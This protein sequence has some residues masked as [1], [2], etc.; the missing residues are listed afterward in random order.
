MVQARS[1]KVI[2]LLPNAAR[3]I[4]AL[5]ENGISFQAAVAD[6]IDNS[7]EAQATRVDVTMMFDGKASWVRVA[8]NGEGMDAKT[9]TEAMRYGTDRNYDEHDL[10]KFGMGMKTAPLSQCRCLTVASRVS[11]SQRRIE[12][13]RWDIQEIE[14]SNRW[15]LQVLSPDECDDTLLDPLNDSTGTVVF[16]ENLDRVIG[17]YSIPN[18]ERA[19][20]GFLAL[21]EELDSHL[22]MVFHRFLSGEAKRKKKLAIYV[23]SNRVEPWDPFARSEPC[24]ERLPVKTI[25]IAT[26]RGEGEVKFTPFVLP[27]QSK[28]SKPSEH[29]RYK[30][31]ESW[32]AQ[33]GFYIYRED[34]LIQSGGWSRMRTQDEHAKLARAALDYGREL[35]G[36]F[37]T[38][39]AKDRVNLPQEL[40]AA[41]EEP[42]KQLV[43]RADEVYRKGGEGSSKPKD[44]PYKP[45]SK[46]AGGGKVADPPEIE[47]APPPA[48]NE[49][50]KALTW[51]AREAQQVQALDEIIKKVRENSPEVADVLGF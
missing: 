4:D 28:F 51:A 11:V 35:D 10:G 18:G 44:A 33:Q 5:R 41:L 22:G 1:G 7:I 13:R 49:I 17:R 8:D 24:T 42:I 46:T 36:V 31:P 34:R 14:R 39:F 26:T 29:A 23:N 25:E 3:T 47:S 15:G 30:G 12:V 48:R 45:G 21:A 40:K 20:R 9:L 32:N 27:P 37:G 19:K 50:R 38:T 6:L 16:W 2:E 43:R